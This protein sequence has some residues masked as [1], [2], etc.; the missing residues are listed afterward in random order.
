MTR[1]QINEAL[2]LSVPFSKIQNL[3]IRHQKERHVP[4]KNEVDPNFFWAGPDFPVLALFLAGVNFCKFWKFPRND[5]A[6]GHRFLIF[7][8]E[9]CRQGM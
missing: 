2:L 1:K 6:N 3:L 8:K 7:K 9:M 5:L 4:P